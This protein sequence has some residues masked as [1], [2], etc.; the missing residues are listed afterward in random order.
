MFRGI[1]SAQYYHGIEQ[2]TNA[3]PS[4]HPTMR[5]NGRQ[6]GI[7]GYSDV[8]AV[9][10][11]DALKFETDE[12]LDKVDSLERQQH[13][14]RTDLKLLHEEQEKDTKTKRDWYP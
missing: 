2:A 3:P 11:N 4:Q 6:C 13:R 8:T 1:D 5:Q 14:A 12:V 10:S 9:D 7:D